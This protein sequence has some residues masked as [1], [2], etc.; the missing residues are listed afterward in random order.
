MASA[1][2]RSRCRRR[3]R[4]RAAS[5]ICSISSRG[6]L[7]RRLRARRAASLDTDRSGGDDDDDDDEGAGGDED[8]DV[9]IGGR[10]PAGFDG[11]GASGNEDGDGDGEG[12]GMTAGGNSPRC[13]SRR[14]RNNSTVPASRRSGSSAFSRSGTGT[15]RMRDRRAPETRPRTVA[16][17]LAGSPGAAAVAALAPSHRSACGSIG[18]AVVWAQQTLP[19][20]RPSKR[21]DC[22]VTSCQADKPP[23]PALAAAAAPSRPKRWPGKPPLRSTLFGGPGP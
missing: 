18:H 12:G 20:A 15:G 1:L 11:G 9:R 8:A 22:R 13:L 14:I 17:V 16:S 4:F 6:A 23:T 2:T 21:A 7:R 19:P 3:S 5:S 10:W